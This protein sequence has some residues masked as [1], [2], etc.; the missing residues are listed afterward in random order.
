MNS[1][2]G[3]FMVCL[4]ALRWAF[5]FHCCLW[6]CII[7]LCFCYKALTY[8]VGCCILALCNLARNDMNDKIISNIYLER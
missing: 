1:V 2:Y 6:W 5:F 7:S 8:L 4:H 3:Y